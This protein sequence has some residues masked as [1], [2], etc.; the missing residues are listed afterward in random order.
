MA[1]TNEDRQKIISSANNLINKIKQ[2][3]MENE[4]KDFIHC[5]KKGIISLQKNMSKDRLKW[6][7]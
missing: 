1:I 6:A 3:N 7:A 4:F 5:V 2:N